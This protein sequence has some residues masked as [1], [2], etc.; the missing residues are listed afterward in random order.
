MIPVRHRLAPCLLLL[1]VYACDRDGTSP[2]DSPIE[3]QRGHPDG[4][5]LQVRGGNSSCW[6]RV[7]Q[8][9]AGVE[10]DV[11][12]FRRTFNEP[13]RRIEIDA[14]DGD[15]TVRYEQFVA[16]H[17]E[18]RVDAGSGSDDVEIAFQPEGS[19]PATPLRVVVE[20]DTR[21]GAD[22]LDFRWNSTAIP[23]L[24]VYAE[25]TMNGTAGPE[26]GDEVI[27]A[28]ESGDADRPVITGMVYNGGA[29]Q[30]GGPDRWAVGATLA[31][32]PQAASAELRLAGVAGPDSA[33]VHANY[34][35][36]LMQQGRVILDADWN[37]GD[38]RFHGDLVLGGAHAQVQASIRAGDGDNNIALRH[39]ARLARYNESDLDF[40]LG[41]G[42]NRL[43]L[44]EL[45]ADS[46]EHVYRLRLGDGDNATTIIF[47]DGQ[48]GATPPA[49]ER[50]VDAAYRTGA[51]SNT[52]EVDGDALGRVKVQFAFEPGAGHNSVLQR[53]RLTQSWP[54]AGAATPT[55]PSQVKVILLGAHEVD[56]LGLRIQDRPPA[57]VS[58]AKPL[59]IVVVSGKARG[60][61]FDF[62]SEPVPLPGNDAEWIYVP[63]RRTFTIAD[64]FVGARLDVVADA[65]EEDSRLVYLQDRIEIAADASANVRLQGGSGQDATTA[66]LRGLTGAGSFNFLAE[67]GSGD[68]F[69]A[70]L[71]VDFA[72]TGPTSLEVRGGAGDHLLALAVPADANTQTPALQLIDGVTGRNAC[73]GTARVVRLL[74][75]DELLRAQLL[76]LIEYIH[77]KEYT[78]SWS[79]VI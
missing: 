14:G 63:V 29:S 41:H 76:S 36:V 1:A 61:T 58:V 40:L 13:I 15:N 7:S 39:D 32:G 33:E 35:G 79:D 43:H 9:A 11:D 56:E 71:A 51:G 38:N 46:G 65:D 69:V 17:I 53:Y 60:G 57:G 74:C 77:G 27:V 4:A 25:L 26:I 24:N 12:G 64:L 72:G 45:L 62:L 66:L 20:V 52:L 22:R 50:V 18:L 8:G 19:A 49:G 70:A 23:G 10:V 21:G 6:I 2:T 42:A 73:F 44:E 59:E 55:A 68:D 5:L 48:H 31:F 3:I 34:S 75:T 28:F 78:D 67:G 30:A 54:A 16:A 37:Q 47:G